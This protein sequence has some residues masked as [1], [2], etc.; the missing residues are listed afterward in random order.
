MKKLRLPPLG[1]LRAFHAVAG[2]LSFKRAAGQ[3][4][5]SATA[6]SHQ[7]RLI[8]SML[9]CRVFERNAQG[10]KLTEVGCILYSGTQSAFTA[11]EDSVVK[12]DHLRQL[13]ALTITTTSNFLTNWLVPRLANFKTDFPLIDLRLH[14]GIERVDLTQ[15]TVDVAIRYRES[16]ETDLH[17]TLL[18]EDRFVVVA[19]PTLGLKAVGDLHS[20]TLL[21]VEHRH[22]P[23]ES[24]DWKHWQQRYGPEELN[25]SRGLHFSD[26]THA[27]QAAV[28]GQGVVIASQLLVGDLL[29]RGILI[30]PFAA[31]LPGANYYLLTL[32][33]IAQ[34]P[35][36]E[37]LREWMLEKMQ[38]R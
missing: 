17:S 30:A 23:A 1:A 14:T 8:E 10:V 4:N 37:A 13:P 5:V 20:A 33:D 29:Q 26:E 16:A 3:L 31:Y 28:A 11:L 15:R 2:C 7:I 19:S 36:V 38:P 24:P 34:R 6:I 18:Y 22:V 27:L 21:H 35:D 12:I 25:I 9:E 32:E